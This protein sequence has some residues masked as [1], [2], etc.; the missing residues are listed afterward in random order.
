[1]LNPMLAVDAALELAG[2]EEML[3]MSSGH[4]G[5]AGQSEAVETR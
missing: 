4:G 2:F 3:E 5:T 1:M